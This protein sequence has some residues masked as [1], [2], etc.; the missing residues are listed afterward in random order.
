MTIEDIF[1]NSS[2]QNGSLF[3]EYRIFILH[4]LQAI[5]DKAKKPLEKSEPNIV[6]APEGIE[7]IRGKTLIRITSG[8]VEPQRLWY[9]T[10]RRADRRIADISS[11]ANILI[12]PMRSLSDEYLQKF[13]ETVKRDSNIKPII[14]DSNKIN[15][16]IENNIRKANEI[17]NSLFTLRIKDVFEK[18]DND[19]ERK[20]N[21][22]IENLK[23]IYKKGTLS[24][25]LGA[26]VSKSAGMPD[27]NTLLNSLFVSY[28]SNK[29]GNSGQLTDIDI[30]QIVN[31]LKDINEQSALI[32][33]RYLKKAL[34]TNNTEAKDFANEITKNLYKLKKDTNVDGS[35]LIQ[36]I[37]N[38]CMPQ[39]TGA[40]VRSVITYN[41]DDLLER[42]FDKRNIHNHSIYS[43]DVNT[44]P[45]DLPIYHVHGFLP[46]NRL[47]Y[48]DLEKSTLVFSE[49]GYH[50]IYSDAYHWSNL[51]QLNCLK[52]NSCL[53]IGLSM[54]DPNLRRL[55]EIAARNT[56]K[57]KHFAFMKRIT[58]E[59]F[60]NDDKNNQI[61]ANEFGATTFLERH[62][63]L[64]EEIMS[65]LGISVI[66]FTDYNEIPQMINKIM[67]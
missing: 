66:W 4:L 29:F 11:F 61:I 38:M 13:S 67:E 24:L 31:R 44:D 37:V 9:T 48:K 14:W 43:D 23:K 15:K 55:L 49:D 8:R 45:D 28:L 53:F 58:K 27:W 5:Q 51:A 39:R 41:F 2:Y 6:V 16:L 60:I 17:A 46:E 32:L 20:R 36:A 35:K 10:Q 62:H 50:K 18:N 26:G 59:K 52:E 19:W 47:K 34:D 30:E 7:S 33:A 22:N 40:K 54:T 64:N 63:L 56:D 21:E 3:P 57:P 12:I 42:E 65:E 1:N 25:L